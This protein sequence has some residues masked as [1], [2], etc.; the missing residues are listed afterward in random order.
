MRALS[1]ATAEGAIARLVGLELHENPYDS[2][3]AAARHG[4]W[5]WAWRYADALLAFHLE[6]E[7]PW[8]NE[9]EAA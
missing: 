4:A 8:H 6:H 5:T 3:D 1:H 7:V 2:A 9:D